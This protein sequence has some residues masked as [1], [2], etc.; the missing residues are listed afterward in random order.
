MPVKQRNFDLSLSE[1]ALTFFLAMAMTAVTIYQ[2]IVG[3]RWAQFYTQ[4]YL[5]TATV[6]L[7]MFPWG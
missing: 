5:I 6:R 4:F 7:V 1:G 2:G 3:Q